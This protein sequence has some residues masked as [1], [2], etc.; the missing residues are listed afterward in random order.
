MI[1]DDTK[2]YI[3]SFILTIGLFTEAFYTG[4]TLSTSF[5]SLVKHDRLNVSDIDPESVVDIEYVNR[6]D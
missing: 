4:N 6:S 3:L 5:L 2:R 1:R